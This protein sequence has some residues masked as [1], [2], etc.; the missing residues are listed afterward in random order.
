MALTDSEIARIKYELRVNVLNIGALPYIGITQMYELVIQPNLLTGA[1][2]TS[3]SAVTASTSPAVASLLL[4]DATGFA[5]GNR[6][7]IDVDDAQEVATVRSVSGSTITAWLSKAHTGTYPVTVES[8]ETIV[9]ELLGRCRNAGNAI[10]TAMAQ[11]GIKRADEVEFFAK[12]EG[13]VFHS[14]VAQQKYWRE[15]LRVALGVRDNSDA[16]AGSRLAI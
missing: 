13:S 11:A 1:T 10:E 5:A 16:G 12:Q 4:T 15:E 2:T 3:A 6:V 9:R 7:A 8:G 14:L